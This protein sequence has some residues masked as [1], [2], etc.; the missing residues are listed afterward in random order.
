MSA[1]QVKRW[2]GRGLSRHWAGIVASAW[3]LGVGAWPARGDTYDW[4]ANASPRNWN[5]SDGQVNWTPAGYPDAIGDVANLVNDITLASTVNLNVPITCGTVNVGDANGSHAFTIAPNGGRLILDNGGSAAQ[6]NQTATSRGDT[7][8]APLLLNGNL[9]LSNASTVHA[10]TVSGQITETGGARS[11]SKDGIGTAILSGANT[12]SGGSTLNAGGLVIGSSGALGSGTFTINGGILEGAYRANPVVTNAVAFNGDLLWGG[13]GA[14]GDTGITF[15]GPVDFGGGTRTLCTTAAKHTGSDYNSY[16]IVFANANV[17]NGALTLYGGGLLPVIFRPAVTTGGTFA[18]G[19]GPITLNGGVFSFRA[20]DNRTAGTSYT[21]SNAI[22]VSNAVNNI[23][24]ANNGTIACRTTFSGDLTLGGD[25]HCTYN[26]NRE[27][28]SMDNAGVSGIGWDYAGR[29]VVTGGDRAIRF[30]AFTAMPGS[31]PR[32][33]GNIQDDGQPRT[34]TIVPSSGGIRTLQLTGTN[35]MSVGS[36]LVIAQAPVTGC[37][38]EMV[39]TNALGPKVTVEY[40]AALLPNHQAGATSSDLHNLLARLA[41][42]TDARPS[43]GVVAVHNAAYMAQNI[44]LSADGYNLDINIGGG[45]DLGS[46][47][48]T[49]TGTITPLNNTWKFGGGAESGAP[50]QISSLLSDNGAT[51][52]RVVIGQPR[53]YGNVDLAAA[54]TYS[55]GT[56]V[57]PDGNLWV[58]TASLGSGPLDLYGTLTLYHDGGT[59]QNIPG[60]IRFHPGGSVY[61]M[62]NHW[63]WTAVQDR[64]GD[65]TPVPLDSGRFA[66]E[67]RSTAAVSESVGDVTFDGGSRLALMRAAPCAVT[68]NVNSLAR[69]PGSRGTLIVSLEGSGGS[70]DNGQYLLVRG[71]A[72]TAV[73]GMLSPQM[74]V[75]NGVGSSAGQSQVW[76]LGTNGASPSALVTNVAYTTGFDS[77]SSTE[78]ADLT[79]TANWTLSADESCWAVCDNYNS[80]SLGLGT[81]TLTVTSGGVII[82]RTTIRNGTLA[83]GAAEGLVYLGNNVSTISAS[84]SGTAGLTVSA[85]AASAQLI[86]SGNNANLTG[87]IYHNGPGVLTLGSATALNAVTPNHLSVRAGGSLSLGGYSVTVDGLG[88]EGTVDSGLYGVTAIGSGLGQGAGPCTLTISNNAVSRGFAG[89]IQNTYAALTL[90]KA[91]DAT[92][93]LSGVST[94]TGPTLV[95]GGA[96]VVDGTLGFTSVTVANG[97]TLGGSGRIYGG[98]TVAGGGH[99]APGSSSGTLAVGSLALNDTSHL[100][101]ELGEPGGTNDLVEVNGDLVLDGVLNVSGLAGF[102]RG[103][104]TLMTYR[105]TLTDNG[106]AVSAL[107][108]IGAGR[109]RIEIDATARE[110][111]LVVPSRGGTTLFVR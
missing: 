4:T 16:P 51:P 63:R 43:R 102:A 48:A 49:F 86:L 34:L 25:L 95:N 100:D 41:N 66:V 69:L 30:S 42:E 38:A 8:S 103:T 108:D 61:L 97:A 93:T 7:I 92:Q 50:L 24:D 22:V 104:Y 74:A 60:T 46:G 14:L 6:I 59:W 109:P 45:K 58:K 79:G 65:D 91:G 9:A 20:P 76:F 32:L 101:F 15:T 31:S 62:N 2:N 75:Y 44:D 88:G 13:F 55:G 11:L 37:R 89:A 39:N 85:G 12:F 99:L 82:T 19:S 94:Y 72:L 21:L 87:G 40:G 57:L 56:T 64:W 110:V 28:L 70:L 83:F 36:R 67:S 105:G 80:G 18:F 106:L 1:H 90:V 53:T 68:L 29:V 107:P 23:L 10:L 26:L 47:F 33:S 77:G 78:I 17:S 73:N 3:V 98:V 96:L 35:Q 71:T 84:I 81:K 27:G 52:R 111:R 54:N 5:N